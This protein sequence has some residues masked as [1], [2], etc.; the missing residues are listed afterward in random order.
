MEEGIKMKIYKT[1]YNSYGDILFRNYFIS[2]KL[3]KE[4][5]KKNKKDCHLP[6]DSNWSIDV[7]EV[8]E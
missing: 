7:I 6:N 1:Y 4:Y 8:I 5:I 2:E 3:A